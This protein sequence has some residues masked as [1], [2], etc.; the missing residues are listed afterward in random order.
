M[1]GVQWVGAMSKSLKKL[2]NLDVSEIISIFVLK[3][4]DLLRHCPPMGEC[5]QVV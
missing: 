5:F 1:G 2:I 4:Y 3:V